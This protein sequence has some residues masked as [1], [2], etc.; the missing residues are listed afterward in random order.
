M[1]RIPERGEIDPRYVWR[2]EDIYE[3]EDAWS[4][5]YDRLTAMTERFAALEGTADRDAKA[6]IRGYFE[7]QE[8][9]EPLSMY[10]MLRRECNNAD[11][12]AQAMNDRL[13]RFMTNLETATS[14]V[15]PE[16]L[17]LPEERLEALAAAPDMK[18][19][20]AFI[21]RLARQKA[22]TLS[23]AEERIL[24]MYSDLERTPDN[25][26]SLFTAVDMKFPDIVLPD[27]TREPLTEG[28]FGRYRVSPDADV[29]RQAFEGIMNTYGSF[30]TTVAT[31]YASSV[32]KDDLGA[33]VRHYPSARAAVMAPLEIP[34]QVYDNLIAVVHES[35][36]LLDEYLRIRKRMMGVD[37]LHMYDLY[38][39]MVTG[40]DASYPFEEA[41]QL[42]K[43]GLAPMGEDYQRLLQK[44]HDER[45]MDV[46]PT[47]SKSSGAF[48]AGD[49]AKVHPFVLLNHNDDLDDAFTMAHE[50][51]HAMHSWFSN[52]AQPY[53]KAGYSLFVAEVA[54]ICNEA[55]LLRSLLKETTE[56]KRRAYL[57]NHFMESFRT[58]C[59]RQTMFAEFEKTAHEMCAAGEPLT[60]ETL[61][62]KY[63]ALNRLYYGDVCV[64][65]DCVANE[66]MRI[67]HFYRAFYVYV[68]ATGLCAAVA[69]SERI[70]NG[71]AEALA[72]YRRFLSA[73]CSV[74]PIEALK[75]AGIDMS[76][77]EPLRAAMRFFEEL[78][79]E[80]RATM[81][82]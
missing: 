50:L 44:A 58:T 11:P 1:N 5:D 61:S 22:H 4:R 29:R 13:Q 47:Q 43:R 51:G 24:S 79:T 46:Y 77:P 8:A 36:P 15:V 66:W 72:D 78:I 52:H 48:S 32:R 65:D 54:S 27:G 28:T 60:K 25:I 45:W 33:R 62:E 31:I 41:F 64:V 9:A 37:E 76:S 38:V 12:A 68:Y 74:P 20:D 10:A 35:I 18:E 7:L 59:F 2:F 63:L 21:R 69:L 57:L 34:E 39:P 70:L 75:L 73:G 14:Y 42:V 67:P 16:L 49:L 82:L 30:G 23:K 6:I 56:P 40:V 26:F 71:G 80:F 19:Y 55:L 81:K 53:A 17:S 3:S